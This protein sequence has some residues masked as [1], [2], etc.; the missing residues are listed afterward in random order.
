M[1][2]QVEITMD[3]LNLTGRQQ[4]GVRPILEDS[5]AERSA[6]MEKYGID[7][8][9]LDAQRR[10]GYRTMRKMQKEMRK[11]QDQTERRDEHPAR[12]P[13]RCQKR[14]APTR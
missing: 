10:P 1:Q 12:R 3:S 11:V 4:D 5:F 7:P 6:I 14:I 2:E 8:A 9:D 13:M